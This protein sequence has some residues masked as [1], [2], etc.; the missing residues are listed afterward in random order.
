MAVTTGLRFAT[1]AAL[2]RLLSPSDFGLMGMIMVV[3]GLAQTFA[4]MGLGAAI[5]QRQNVPNS[6][7]SSIFWANVLTG[8][9]LFL[10]I[11]LTRPLAAN[12]FRQPDLTTYLIIA[13]VMF[14]IAPLGQVFG[15]VLSKELRFETLSKIETTSTVISSFSA[16]GFALAK[17]GV[18]SLILSELV[19]RLVT[20]IMLVFV[21]RK[22]WLPNFHFSIKEVRSYVRFGMFQTGERVLN[23]FTANVDYIIIGR[24]LGAAP[25]GFYALAYNL[26]TF[27]LSKINPII[28][29][30]AY[31]SFSKIQDDNFKM[32]QGYCKVIN[33]ITALSFPMLAGMFVI[34][35]EFIRLVYGAKWEPSIVV[36]QI[37][38]VVGASKSLGNPNG[39]VLLAKGRADIGFYWNVFA[40]AVTSA[41]V[42]L[43]VRWG[44]TGVAFGLLLLE[45]PFF[46]IIQPIVIKLI[47]LNLRQFFKAIQ[48]PL[49][50]SV[51]MLAGMIPLKLVLRNASMLSLIIAT[52]ILGATIYTVSYYIKDKAFFAE[53]RSMVR[54]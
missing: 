33:Y 12:Y 3:T 4:D 28:T 46:F 48:S 50:C 8:I 32:G 17:F 16:V 41:V 20:L 13:A 25:L 54:R 53:V 1:L 14:L 10:G 15:V 42:A 18:L 36:L 21:F 24:L 26:M 11:L 44:I 22:I 29:R 34:A 6:H 40:V 47:D 43:S 52:V 7:L 2:A 30:V 37:F 23:Y 49:F 38:C 5:I 51:I 35:P 45:V 27:P 19:G 31:P 9:L 39:S